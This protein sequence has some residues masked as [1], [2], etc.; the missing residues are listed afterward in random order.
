MTTV[1]TETI[2][3]LADLEPVPFPVLSL[4]L[5]AQ[6]DSVGRDRISAFLR[7]TLAQPLST[8][9]P[10]SPEHE[11]LSQDIARIERYVGESLQPSA[12]GVA[13]FA[14][15][16]AERFFEAVQLEAPVERHALYVGDRPHLYPLALLDERYPRYAAVV[17]DTNVARI[18]VFGT[19]RIERKE[20]V[21]G[22][23][24]KR[25]KAGGWSQARF[26]RHVD[27]YHLQHVKEVVDRLDRIV[28][29]EGIEQVILIGDDVVVSLLREQLPTRLS[30][31]IIDVLRLGARASDRDVLSATLEVLRQKDADTDAAIVG[32][33]FDEV[34]SGGLGV[35]G[36]RATLDALGLGQ[37]DLLLITSEPA[38]I[39]DAQRVAQEADG[40][41]ERSLVEEEP[42]PPAEDRAAN[43]LVALARQTSAGVRFIEDPALL[44]DVGG[45]GALL[46]FHI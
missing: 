42:A 18:F 8:Y 5:N 21:T 31:R 16:G 3:R 37:V 33:L 40:R 6:P 4:Y 34:R 7:K 46:R 44:A 12:N 23:K 29:D 27:H 11:S 19:H 25:V 1:L 35:A 43:H 30:E 38:L 14:C 24:T 32:R 22:Q 15:A 2:D 13:I 45:V 39:G 10:A 36:A 28:R 9:R 17:A 20:R 41:V 26:Q